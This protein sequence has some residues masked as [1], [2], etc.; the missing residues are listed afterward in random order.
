MTDN[1]IYPARFT[2]TPPSD[3]GQWRSDQQ[4]KDRTRLLE[5]ERGLRDGTIG[6]KF[7]DPCALAAAKENG[8][9][10]RRA[11]E[12]FGIAGAAIG[13]ALAA[14]GQPGRKRGTDR[15]ERYMVDPL[16]GDRSKPRKLLLNVFGYLELADTIA[17]L[18][19]ED[20]GECKIAL[21]KK[22]RIWARGVSNPRN[23]L[24][25]ERASHLTTMIHEMAGAVVRSTG[26]SDTLRR[27]REIPGAWRFG[28]S[29]FVTAS[30]RCL[31]Q[32]AL[33]GA[34]EHWTDA[35]CLPTIPLLRWQHSEIRTS[36][37]ISD[38][39]SASPTNGDDLFGTEFAGAVSDARFLLYRE[40]GLTIGPAANLKDIAPMF[41]SRAR[42]ALEL[43]GVA[44]GDGVTLIP[45]FTL[46]PVD[47]GTWMIPPAPFQR[48]IDGIW[49]R[50]LPL[51]PLHDAEAFVQSENDDPIYFAFDPRDPASPAFEHWY[52][53]WWPVNEDTVAYWLDRTNVDGAESLIASRPGEVSSHEF[54]HPYG[55]IA[56][57]LEHAIV[58]GD[59]QRA[60]ADA[61]L[62]IADKLMAREA[63][64]RAA[65]GRKEDGQ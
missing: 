28:Q 53:T 54:W 20:A 5:I 35:P 39:G 21:L 6:P 46:K 37:R 61:A 3:L 33:L 49:R 59:V 31:S 2:R 30:R 24:A 43:P 62:D 63:E 26:L 38:I 65:D 19:G 50:V 45:D 40:V 60:L 47:D 32:S 57:D 13:K 29:G 10:V 14:R 55:T 25:A 51:T 11:R 8:A 36:V 52:L 1:V 34:L 42:V 9:A 15:Y 18:T 16:K 27:A 23:D 4:I 12:E 58:S 7:G 64:W 56:H 44:A 41:A 17:G 22:T 48:Q